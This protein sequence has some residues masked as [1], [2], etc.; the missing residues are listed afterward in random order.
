MIK[1]AKAINL[2]HCRFWLLPQKAIYWQKKKI[3]MIADLHI[4]KSGHFRK[5]G[6]PV[7][8][9]VNTS[10]IDRMDE[11]IQEV[12]P[13]HLIILGDLFHSRANK[14]WE[15]FQSWR[16]KQPKLEV[17]LVI[18]NHDILPSSAYHSSRINLFKRVTID[19][20][21]L[22]HDLNE[23]GAD[24]DITNH[25]ILSGHIHPAVQ[26]KGKGRQSMKLPCFYFG[27][28]QG[29]LPA[30]GQFTGTHVIEP[31]KGEKVYTIADS[32]ILDMNTG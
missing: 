15:Q 19:S 11:L 26:L 21:L 24:K 25:Y 14:E 4:G 16:K 28:E 20:F 5:H 3:L 2:N 9:R 29:I 12:E 10:N 27:H 7:P 23:I 30:F 8:G 6:I 18:G 22:I 1:N 32:Q 17:S 13:E 31:R